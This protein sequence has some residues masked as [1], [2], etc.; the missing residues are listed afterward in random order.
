MYDVVL[1]Q[2][3]GLP[4]YQNLLLIFYDHIKTI[5]TN[6][7]LLFRQNKQITRYDGRRCIGDYVHRLGLAYIFIAEIMKWVQR[8]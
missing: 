8:E 6:I 4:R 5:C 3:L 7:Q 1:K 2:L